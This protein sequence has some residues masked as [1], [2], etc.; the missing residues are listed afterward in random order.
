MPGGHHANTPLLRQIATRV[1]AA[2]LL[3]L[4][5]GYWYTDQSNGFKGLS[6]RFLIDARVQPFREIFQGHSLLVYLNYAAATHGFTI[7]Q[8]P[9]S[10]SYPASGPIPTRLTGVGHVARHL[11]DYLRIVAGRCNPR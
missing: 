2:G 4:A 7:V 8:T 6:R 3:W 5:T 11:V 9:T 1:V 10:R